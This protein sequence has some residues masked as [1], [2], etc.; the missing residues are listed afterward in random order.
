MIFTLDLFAE[1]NRRFP[2][3][4]VH[5]ETYVPVRHCLLAHNPT[6][7]AISAENINKLYSH[8]QAWGQCKKYLSK[9]LKGIERID[10]SSTS[11]A[12]QIVAK[13]V[14]GQ[15]AAI[16]SVTAARLYGLTCIA[17]GIEDSDDNST[18]FFI[19]SRKTSANEA[20]RQY[21]L[22]NALSESSKSFKM[23]FVFKVDHENPGALADSLAVF[24]TYNLNLTSINSRPSGD[25]P[26]HYVFF[27]EIEGQQLVGR[28][29][30]IKAAFKDIEAVT[31]SWR[32]LGAWKNELA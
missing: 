17:E 2:D 28:M 10:V 27:V 25:V 6:D 3:I 4:F 1:A 7:N 29:D 16:S 18:R 13:D 12:A 23:L 5:G 15:S 24:K 22:S 26:W 14:S 8:P 32:C 20:D 9:H 11:K 21:I 19:L 31:K 30:H